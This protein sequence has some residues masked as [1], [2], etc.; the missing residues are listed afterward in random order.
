MSSSTLQTCWLA[1]PLMLRFGG[2]MVLASLNDSGIVL[3]SMIDILDAK[4]ITHVDKAQVKP[5]ME[6]SDIHTR[7]GIPNMVRHTHG[8]LGSVSR[9]ATTRLLNPF[10]ISGCS[11]KP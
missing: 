6:K 11:E 4:A 8:R 2:V 7:E 5:G 3:S 9:G 1:R 10:T